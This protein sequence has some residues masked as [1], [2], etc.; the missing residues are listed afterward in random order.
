MPKQTRKRS[1]LL[2]KLP[3]ELQ[4]IRQAYPQASVEL[5][6]TDEHRIG[7]KP[8]LRRVWALKGS[9]VKAVVAQR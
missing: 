5:W 9:A 2:K 1:V 8:I 4:A 7:L 6:S 3:E